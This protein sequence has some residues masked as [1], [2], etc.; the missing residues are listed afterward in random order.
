MGAYHL[1]MFWNFQNLIFNDQKIKQSSTQDLNSSIIS[2]PSLSLKYFV[3][4][5]VK[6]FVS[7]KQPTLKQEYGWAGFRGITVPIN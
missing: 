5:L 6:G 2:F 1:N 4:L 3:S 7:S